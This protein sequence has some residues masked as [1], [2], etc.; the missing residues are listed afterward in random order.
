MHSYQCDVSGGGGRAH[1]EAGLPDGTTAIECPG[2]CTDSPA[3]QIKVIGL[4]C[5]T[6]KHVRVS[7][8][9]PEMFGRKCNY[10]NKLNQTKFYVEFNC[11]IAQTDQKP[12]PEQN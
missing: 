10:I 8:N 2:E 3:A 11:L 4:F 5:N 9:V 1:V 7:F 6:K 12:T